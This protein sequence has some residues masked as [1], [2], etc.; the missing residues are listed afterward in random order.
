MNWHR[1]IQ[2]AAGLGEQAVAGLVRLAG[3]RYFDGAHFDRIY[4]KPDPWGYAT[5]PYEAARRRALLAALPR[6]RYRA[7]LEIGCGEGLTTRLLAERADRVIGLDISAAAVALARISSLPRNVTVATG[8]LLVAAPR[9]APPGAFDLVICAEVLYYCY[10]WPLGPSSRLVRDRVVGWLA[11]GG[12]L[13]LQHPRHDLVHY[14]FDRLAKGGD[15]RRGARDGWGFGPPLVPVERRHVPLAPRPF[16]IAVY[17]RA[18]DALVDGAGRSPVPG[19]AA[20]AAGSL[21]PAV[22]HAVTGGSDEQG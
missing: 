2:L 10:R 22:Q 7:V 9:A 16:T 1:G 12:D 8:D 14:P 21:E 18:H 13:V 4:G 11:P 3:A 5:S 6:K 15:G 20:R 19:S 17:R